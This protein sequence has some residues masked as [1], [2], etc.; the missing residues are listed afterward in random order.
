MTIWDIFSAA[1]FF[2]DLFKEVI[3]IKRR[4]SS[5]FIDNIIIASDSDLNPDHLFLE[6]FIS[7]T[8]SFPWSITGVSIVRPSGREFRCCIDDFGTFGGKVIPTEIPIFLPAY[9]TLRVTFQF[10]HDPKLTAWLQRIHQKQ[11][12]FY[13]RIHTPANTFGSL[14]RARFVPMEDWYWKLP[15]GQ[16]RQ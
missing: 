12:R 4:K 11:K 8:S 2:F 16:S 7:N 9:Q 3:G 1:S 13:V 14:V 15:D 6:A 5:I 10:E